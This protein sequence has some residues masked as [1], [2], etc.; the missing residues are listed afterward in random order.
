MGWMPTSSTASQCAKFVF[1]ARL[2]G[3][4]RSMKTVTIIGVDLAKNVFQLHGATE[5]GS[6]AFRRKL[7]RLQFSRFMASHLPCVVAMEACGSSHYWARRLLDDYKQCQV[8]ALLPPWPSKP[9]HPRCRPSSAVAISPLGSDWFLDRNRL[10]ASNDLG[11]YR[12]WAS[13][14]FGGCSLLAPWRWLDGHL[15]GVRPSAPGSPA[16]WLENRVCWWQSRWLTR[17]PVASGPC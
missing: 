1:L 7:S 5:S 6:T 8:W 15:V 16:Y 17:W 11:G 9:S 3:R 13:A 10:A 4:L 12:R 2:K 14:T